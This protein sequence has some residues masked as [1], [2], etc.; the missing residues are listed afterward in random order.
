M[1]LLS[2]TNVALSLAALLIAHRVYWETTTGARQRDFKKKNGCLPAKPRQNHFFPSFIPHFGIDFIVSN[3]RAIR[4]DK[5]LKLWES[6]IRNTGNTMEIDVFRMKIF[7]TADPENMKCMLATNFDVWSLGQ[8][9]IQQMSEILGF[10]I[11]T[12]EGKAWKHSRE[13]LRPCFERTA[14]ADVSRLEVHTQRL[15]KLLPTNGDEVNLQPIFHELTL[16][17]ATDLLFGRSTNSLDRNDKSKEVQ[18]FIQAF[19]YSIDPF[20]NPKVQK[21]GYFGFLLPDSQRKRSIK[22]IQGRSIYWLATHLQD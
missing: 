9:R 1:A 13:M 21:Y 5:M 2:F 12:N 20:Q 10:G 15:L 18:D 11:F 4:R 16:D 3:F 6:D 7:V 22:T 19:E 17:V 8:E 14:V